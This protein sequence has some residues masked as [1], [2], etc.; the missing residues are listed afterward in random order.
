MSTNN[1]S[2]GGLG[3]GY[4]QDFRVLN[5]VAKYTS[6]FIPASTNPDILPDTPSGVSGGS[7]LAKVTDGAVSFDGTGDHLNVG[8]SSDYTF[9]TGDYTLEMFVYHTS[10]SGQQTY[11]SDPVGNS[12]GVYFYKDSN[13]KLGLYYSGQIA[14]GDTN[15]AAN[16]WTHIAISRTG[17][18]SKLFQDGI[19][20]GSGSDSTNLTATQ[21]YIGDS[22]TTSGEMFGFISNVRVI[23]G[24]ALYTT[25]FTP[26]TREL[27]NVTNTKLLCCQSNTSA[28]S[29]TVTPGTFSNS[30]VVYSSGIAGSQDTSS[31]GG[32]VAA[33]DGKLGSSDSDG[34]YPAAGQ[35]LTWTPANSALGTTLPYSSSIRVYVKV[36]A[37]GD[38]GGLIVIGANGSQTV[39]AGSVGTRYVDISAAS[40]PI[41][42]IAW[43]RASSGGQGVGLQAVEVDGTTLIDGLAGKTVTRA[44]DA[45]ATNFNPFNTDINTVRGQETGYNTLNPLDKS[46]QTNIVLTNGNLDAANTSSSGQGRVDGTIAFSSGKWYFEGTV[47]GSSNYHEIGIIKTD[48]ALAYGIGFYSGGYS[49][50][51]GGNKFNNNGTVTYGGSY[52]T[53]DT[54]GVAFN[55]DEGTLVFYKNGVSRGTAYTGLSGEFTFTVGTYSSGANFGW[56]SNFG[57]KP[58]KFPP[59]AGFQPLNGANVKLDTVVGLNPDQYVKT[60]LWTG[61]D[62]ARS[63][64]TG[65]APDLV[66]IKDRSITKDPVLCDSVRGAGETLRPDDSAANVTAIQ[67]VSSF[68]S[69]GFSVGTDSGVNNNNDNFVGWT[70]KAGGNKNTFN[71]D[72]VGYA[73]AAA[74]GLTGGSITPTGSSVGTRQ[75]FSIIKYTGTGS[76]ASV[77]H[78]LQN[79]PQ[80]IIVK[81]LD[82]TSGW[83]A[84]YHHSMGNTHALYL[85]DN[86]SKV[87][88]SFWNDT[89]PT[90]SVFTIGANANTNSSNDFISY[91]WHDV[92]G[93]QK[94]GTYEGSGNINTGPFVELGF[95]PALLIV[96]NMD[97]TENWYI[98]DTKRS[99]SNVAYQSLQANSNG[100]E[101]TGNTN[102]RLDLL[103]NG[104]KLRQGNGPNN[105]NTYIYCA[106]AEAPTFNLFGAQ[107]N[108]R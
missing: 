36:D 82:S 37:N 38:D 102:S 100:A 94:F 75:G 101:E 97:D 35:T 69:N 10:I 70:W 62:V 41:T 46:P 12:A 92:P 45:A 17:G 93:L 8:S 73:S 83:W 48:Q 105:A 25:D 29:A 1:G 61:N 31:G 47:T 22:A 74:A 27:T 104:F 11:F 58:F 2:F 56:S 15:I 84:V 49:Y 20:V 81:D 39:D 86:Q 98:Y 14:T 19:L 96:K 65:N 9:G 4:I 16:K 23:K 7:K 87:D 68:N 89:T 80:F 44:G 99:P 106:W 50:N 3:I 108:A 33:F 54:I 6:N 5:G 64:V 28:N 95:K 59:P 13:N 63:I 77:S 60:V 53:G 24:T 67:R 107:S 18:T 26:P 52:T 34:S 76:N 57:Q 85:N 79:I 55:L 32:S 30:G 72:D 66:W 103:S 88:S 40:S 42:S 51:Q 78:G 71:K 43:S 90:S 21:Y 91:L